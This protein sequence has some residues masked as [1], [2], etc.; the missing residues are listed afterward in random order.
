MSVQSGALVTATIQLIDQNGITMLGLVSY[1][2]GNDLLTLDPYKKLEPGTLFTVTL[3]VTDTLTD[4]F[5][6]QLEVSEEWV[7]ATALDTSPPVLDILYPQSGDTVGDYVDVFGTITDETLK[8]YRLEYGEGSSPTTWTEIIAGGE[9]HIIN[10]LIGIWD[11]TGLDNDTYTLRLFAEDNFGNSAEISN[12]VSIS[13]TTPD[14]GLLYVTPS[15]VVAGTATSIDVVGFNFV[16]TAE[17]YFDSVL[18]TEVEWIDS[19]TLSVVVPGNLGEGIYD[20]TVMNGDNKSVTLTDA[21]TIVPEVLDGTIIYLPLIQNKMQTG[22]KPESNSL[23][24]IPFTYKISDIF[25]RFLLN[26][27][28]SIFIKRY[29]YYE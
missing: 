2:P 24:I 27:D 22:D 28:I 13:N 12:T 26:T 14:P 18:L 29:L 10:H 21:L 11:T 7:F 16:R 15:E 9:V 5:N 6:N 20:V 19:T 8:E 4:E 3:P 25:N 23:L 17:V 1:D